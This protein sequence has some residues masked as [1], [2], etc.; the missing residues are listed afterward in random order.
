MGNLINTE[1]W[2]GRSQVRYVEECLWWNGMV[3]RREIMEKYGCSGQ[4]ASAVL[5][6]YRELNPKAMSYDLSVKRYLADP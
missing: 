1:S 2:L 5:Q 4:H 6:A 3:S